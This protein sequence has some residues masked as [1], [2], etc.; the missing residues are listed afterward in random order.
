MLHGTEPDL[1]FLRVI[2]ARVFVHIETDSKT[3][4]LKTVEKRLVGY[5]NNSKSYRVYNP[6]TRRIM[7]SR[8]IIFIETP[9]RLFP[10]PLEETPQ[11][12]NPLSNGMD[13][14]NY[15]TDDD[16]FL[17]DLRSY[18]SVLEPI[19]GASAHHIAVGGLSDNPPVT[20]FVERISEIARRDTLDGGAV[21]P[22][23]ERAMPGGEPTDGVSQEV[24]LEPQEQAV[25]PT[26][27]SLETPLAGSQTL[28]QRR[29]SRPEATPAVT[30][31]GTT[32]KSF[33]RRNA[34]NRS[35]SAHLA[36]IATG[37]ALSE[38]RGL[39]LYPKE[40]LPDIAHETYGADSAVEYA[41]AATT[42]QSCSA[43][44]N[45]EI[46]PS[47]FK[48]AMTLPAEAQWKAGASDMA[49]ASLKK[50]DVYTLLPATFVPTGHKITGSRWV[51]KV[52]VDNSHK[53]RVVVLGSEQL[54]GMR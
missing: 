22:P 6:A 9:S 49:M 52:K 18:T 50:N 3:F 38:L 35:E 44:E 32:A 20:E 13:D 43:G 23:Q 41:Y 14:H 15:I 54:P 5:S 2:G 24:V 8:N 39:R 28:Q 42:I 25:S 51:Y 46:T 31:V 48:E 19:P 26:G 10:P 17:R 21:G 11:Q 12:V 34:H 53:G 16:D 29:H 30:R 47:T 40:T 37:P 1:R 36:A 33:V 27:T 4:K 7:E 45:A